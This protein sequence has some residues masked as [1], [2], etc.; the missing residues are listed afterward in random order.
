MAGSDRATG[1][2]K[3][4][5]DGRRS[6]ARPS[7]AHPALSQVAD[8]LERHYGRPGLEPRG[9]LVASL[10]GTVLSQN[11][12]DVNSGR[13]FASLVERFPRWEDVARAPV[14]SIESAIKSGGLARTKSR[15][16]RSLLKRIE[17]E[18]GKIDLGFLRGM[19]TDDVL[20]YLM[21]FDGVGRKTAACVALFELGRDIVPVDTHVHRVISRLGVLGASRS[22]EDTFER[23]RQA[24]PEG[25]A[26]SLH[27]NLVRLGRELCRPGRPR[28]AECPLRGW[29]ANA[30]TGGS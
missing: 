12:S 11:T 14:R 7:E 26:L 22:P 27:L 5:R 1:A 2:P 3:R 15:R 4:V 19:A 20:E 8:A 25:R 13:A 6:P 28:C 17:A 23:L 9:D 29:C 24:A 10:V 21:R 16:I 30:T 18:R